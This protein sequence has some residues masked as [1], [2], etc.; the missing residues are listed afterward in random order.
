MHR[1]QAAEVHNTKTNLIFLL[2]LSGP[3]YLAI[4]E[5]CKNCFFKMKRE[6]GMADY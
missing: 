6:V 4:R 2:R 3:V 1:H 5:K